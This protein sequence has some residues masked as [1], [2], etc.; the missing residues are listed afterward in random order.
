MSKLLTI[1]FY[2]PFIINPQEISF[3]ENNPNLEVIISEIESQ[4]DLKFAYGDDVNPTTKLVGRFS[5]E[6]ENLDEVLNQLSRRTPY[7]MS[8]IG[9]NIAISVRSTSKKPKIN[10][11]EI[12]FLVVGNVT[13]PNGVPLPSVTIQEEGT[14]NG[15]LTDFDGNFTITV[16]SNE[17]VLVFTYIGMET[18][19]RT[20]GDST[21]M[22][23]QMEEDS[24]AL[25]EVVV[26]G[27]GS[28][29]KRDL[30][31]SVGSVEMD[32]MRSRPMVDFGQALQ[33]KLAGVE[34]I[35]GS[36]RPGSLTSIQI[37][38]ASSISAGG[39]PLIV[40]DGVQLPGFDLNS[41]NSSAIE[42]IQV[43][44]DAAS[45]SI[46][47]SRGANGVILVTTKAGRGKP[48]LHF[49][50]TSSLQ[51]VIRK[52]DVMNSAEYAQTAIDAAQNGWIGQGGDPNAPNTIEARGDYRYTWPVALENPENLI[53]TDWQDVIFRVAPMHQLN[54]GYSASDE[55]SNFFVSGGYT[56]QEGIV[57]GSA[58]QQYSMN[59]SAKTEIND[60]LDIGGMLNSVY[61]HE[62]V[63]YDRIVEW[64]VQYPSIYPVYGEG[65]Y[66][67]A[68]LTLDGFENYSSILFRPFNGH[69]LFR[70]NDDIQNS[71]F[72]GMGNMFVD[73]GLMKNLSFRTSFNAFYRQRQNSNYGPRD[74]NIGPAT[75]GPGD[76]SVGTNRTLSYTWANLLTY[77]LELEDHSFN[78]L[79]GYEY[80]HRDYYMFSASRRGYDSDNLHTLSAGSE[81]TG[82]DDDAYQTNLISYLGRINY[83]LLDKYIMAGSIRRDGSSRFGLNNKWGIFW[84]LSGAWRVSSEDFLSSSSLVSNLKLKAS[85]GV[86]GNDNFADYIWMARINQARTAL[87]DNLLTIYYPSNIANPD[88]EW[89]GTKQLNIGMDLG[90]W[91]DRITLEA[92][93]YRS[94]SDNL[95]LNVP[96][97]STSGF[98]SAFSNN[99]ELMNRGLELNLL[100]Q[101]IQKD[102][103]SWSTQLNFSLNRGEITKLGRD[104]APMFYGGIGAIQKINKVGATPFSFFGYKYDGVYMN[105]AEI[106]ADPAAPSGTTLGEGRYV[107]LN[108]NGEI[109]P[110]DRTIIGGTEADFRLG[111]TNNFNI[112]NF[113]L[114]FLFKAVVGGEIHDRNAVR[115]MLYHEGRNYLDRI[116]NRW[117]SVE[118]PGDGY[119]YKLSVDIRGMEKTASSYWIHSGSFLRMEN[120]TIG[121][122]IPEEVVSRYSVSQARIFFNGTN[123]FLLSE[124]P[125][126]DPQTF[127]GGANNPLHRGVSGIA[128]PSATVYS[129]GL[130]IKF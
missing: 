29:N 88:L 114:S 13:D 78:I 119:H 92:N 91:E 44:K 64:A 84:S 56:N 50:Y 4:T 32:E 94:V 95:L 121:Y 12:Q 7:N 82:A 15:A 10:K 1:F 53:D 49:D 25:E 48:M 103:M 99:G 6:K 120:L 80:N 38:G 37:R 101:N 116:N 76:Y 105:Q 89:E 40:V 122:N 66:L 96:I 102:R 54:V 20:V 111:L 59:M 97:P 79:A 110:G 67:G 21:T 16:T 45:S 108:G 112:G 130:N 3:D 30:T 127:E 100:T 33:G 115:S 73:L 77:D 113:D 117:R 124:A 106:D 24:E 47:G 83:S 57:L 93:I 5:F 39:S 35:N 36:G 42:S 62:D 31:G 75:I 34:V 126:F 65:G 87:G 51:Q 17:S 86:T 104:N 28:I 60:W 18:I 41:I 63:T 90:L 19:R 2:L 98:T 61:D 109:D 26:V 14:N 27:Y 58:Y 11:S 129:L 70:I 72:T 69:P 9:N 74:R 8:I 43:L 22:N 128:Y 55:K 71:G 52:I 125:V 68:P 107:D 118:E 46:Y 85:Y 81:V 23:V 123:L